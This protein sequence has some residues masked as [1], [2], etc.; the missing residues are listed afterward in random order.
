MRES[1]LKANRFGHG[2]AVTAFFLIA[3]LLTSAAALAGV[4]EFERPLRADSPLPKGIVFPSV[5]DSAIDPAGDTL[6]SGTPQLDITSI[7]A[8]VIGDDLVIAVVFADEISAPTSGEANAL[9]GFIDIDA[10]QDGS[11]GRVPWVDTLTGMNASGLG[12]EFYVD[13]FTYD[14]ADRAVDVV[15]EATDTVVGRAPASFAAA[16]F[17]VAIPL[18]LLGG[19]NQ[20]DIAV[21]IGTLTETPTDIAPNQGSVASSPDGNAIVLHGGRFTVEVDW[22]NFEGQTGNGKLVS[23]SDDSMVLYFFDADNWEFLIKVIDGCDF[24]D[25]YWVFAA[26]TTNVEYTITVTDTLGNE[27][28]ITYDNELGQPAKPVLDTTAFA[29]CP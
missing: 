16:S 17:T 3:I 5:K 1:V 4:R 12:N 21:A 20:V 22:R 24:N 14:N 25:H 6:G 7:S 19:D 13:L 10:D 8:Q 27:P 28:P 11:T 29:T 9:D 26:A 18:D 15:D 23:K 2:T